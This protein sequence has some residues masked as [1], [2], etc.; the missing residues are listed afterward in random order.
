YNDQGLPTDYTI[1]PVTG[2]YGEVR[3][4]YTATGQLA[5]KHTADGSCNW[6]F[7]GTPIPNTPSYLAPDGNQY[8]NNS[9]VDTRN[10]L[11]VGTAVENGSGAVV[12]TASNAYD[13]NT[14]IAQT[15]SATTYDDGRGDWQW[16]SQTEHSYQY[17][18]ED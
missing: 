17:D 15:V 12:S 18:G 9:I 5:C 16:I 13:A 2:S 6:F 7:D 4:D 8:S 10:L 1:Y 3:L 14:R 11:A